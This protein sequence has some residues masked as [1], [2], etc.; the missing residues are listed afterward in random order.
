MREQLGSLVEV[1]EQLIDAFERAQIPYALGGAIAYSAWAEPRATRDVDLNVWLDIEQ[2]EPAFAALERCGV[3]LDR[4]AARRGAVERGMFV[5]Y[6]GEYRIDVFVPS[7]PFYEEAL[8]RRQRVRLAE[9]DTWV[10]SPES[11][12]VFKM[13][14]YRPKDLADVA[15]LLDIQGKS[16]DPAFVR[17][18]LVNMLGEGDERIVTWDRLVRA[19]REHL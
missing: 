18:W 12:A 8:A 4:V 15:R 7:V 14:F 6:R 11:L 10:L 16:F 9:R 13:L 3:D 17:Q 19:H 5:V 2:F 1:V